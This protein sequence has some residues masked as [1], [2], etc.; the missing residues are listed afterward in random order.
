[1][2]GLLWTEEKSLEY[3][4]QAL[5][6]I[7]EIIR[8]KSGA[9]GKMFLWIIFNNV[10][11]VEYVREE[12]AFIPGDNI[13]GMKDFRSIPT[14]VHENTLLV[15]VDSNFDDEKLSIT[16]IPKRRARLSSRRERRKTEEKEFLIEFKGEIEPEK[17]AC[18]K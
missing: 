10:Q 6:A 15:E 18:A 4:K 7:Q 12:F 9:S 8:F 1:M 13:R 3:G 5:A 11:W 17:D 14:H 2:S 16:T